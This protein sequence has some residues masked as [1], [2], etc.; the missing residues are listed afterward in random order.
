MYEHADILTVLENAGLGTIGTDIFAYHS[1]PEVK[2]CL[3]VYPSNDPP[4]IDPERPFYLRGKFQVI[5]RNPDYVTGLDLCKQVQAALSFDETET[6]QMKVKQCRPLYQA[7][8][9]RRSESGDIEMSITFQVIY[10]QK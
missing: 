2:A 5:I 6:T 1:P 4:I 8:V 3:I 10:V 7:R 9:Y